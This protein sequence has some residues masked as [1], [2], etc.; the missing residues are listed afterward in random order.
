MFEN[1]RVDANLLVRSA[2]AGLVCLLFSFGLA[3]AAQAEEFQVI[4]NASNPVSSLKAS[5]VSNLFRGK[6]RQWDHGDKVTPVD[7]SASSS[8]RANFSKQ[9]HNKS[10]AGIKSYWQQQIFSGRGVP[11][12][13]VRSDNEV[14]AY[15]QRNPGGIGYVSAGTSLRGVK[16]IEVR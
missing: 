1:P 13:E 3:S 10:V 6:V 9:V 11:P 12:P 4:V 8:V 14:V 2:V 7:K 15:V 5:Y 16:A